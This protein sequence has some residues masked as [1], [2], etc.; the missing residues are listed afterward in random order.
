WVV[1]SD[2]AFEEAAVEASL[3]RAQQL[4][5][6]RAGR[7]SGGRASRRVSA[8]LFRL[9]PTG[10]P[11]G[12]ILWK[13]LVAVARTQRVRNAVLALASLSIVVAVLS[14]DP[15]GTLAEIAG[16]LAVSWAGITIVTGP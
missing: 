2:T 13:N 12:A 5:D 8:P 14:F 7:A 3:R 9:A 11:A 4:A 6:R 10:W 15:D 16:W 1:R